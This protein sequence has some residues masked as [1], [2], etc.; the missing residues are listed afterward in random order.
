MRK[1]G[2]ELGFAPL[3]EARRVSQFG[4]KAFQAT[5]F[6]AVALV[7]AAAGF[8]MNERGNGSTNGQAAGAALLFAYVVSW[9]LTKG[10]TWVA[11]S[12]SRRRVIRPEAKCPELTSYAKELPTADWSRRKLPE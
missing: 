4:W 6:V 9:L 2:V 3:Q 1:A 10:L 12:L 11:D 5:V 8:D 7:F